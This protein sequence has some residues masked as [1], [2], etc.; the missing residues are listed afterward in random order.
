MRLARACVVVLG[1]VAFVI[2]L[3][4][5]TIHE[6]I[7]TASSIGS[8]RLIVVTLFGLFTRLGGPAAAIA[9]LITGAGVWVAGVFFAFT[10]VPY[11]LAI[12]L[13]AL[14]Y[15]AISLFFRR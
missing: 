13:A 6:L 9:A 1:L 5:T 7:E 12:A 11:A 14:A 3:R 8:A 15:L 2:A 4:S 10:S